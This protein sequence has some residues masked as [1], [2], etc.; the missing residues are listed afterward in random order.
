M[1]CS[2]GRKS[3]GSAAGVAFVR[4]DSASERQKN[5]MTGVKIN[6]I[7]LLLGRLALKYRENYFF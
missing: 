1:L 4:H 3:L 5:C 7:I 2:A 6:N